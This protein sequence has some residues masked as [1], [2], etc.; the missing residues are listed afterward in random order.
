MIKVVS[1][2]VNLAGS[3]AADPSGADADFAGLLEVRI[4]A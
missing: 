1:R 3:F 2:R 4:C